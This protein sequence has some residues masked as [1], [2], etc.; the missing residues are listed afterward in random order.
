MDSAKNVRWIIPC[1]K[2]DI[3]RVNKQYDRH[4]NSKFDPN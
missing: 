3:V 1:K 2:F 4:A